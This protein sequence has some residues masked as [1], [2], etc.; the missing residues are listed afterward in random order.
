M[1]TEGGSACRIRTTN[2]AL[3]A[4]LAA[5]VV[6]GACS[7][8]APGANGASPAAAGIDPCALVTRADAERLLG[9]RVKPALRGKSRLMATG[10]TCDYVVAAPTASVGGVSGIDLTVYDDA[11]VRAPYSMF[12]S[13]A[14][15]FRY[16]MHALRVS[17]AL[18]V[19]V[20]GLGAAAYW[21]PGKD[22]LHL[23]DRG[24]YVTLDVEPAAVAP[25]SAGPS[26][27][28]HE[29]VR[30]AADIA[31]ARETVLPRLATPPSL[32]THSPHGG[33]RG[34]SS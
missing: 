9:T 24:V 20:N 17:G 29:A 26:D 11:T 13:A 2:G 7:R 31:L 19:A 32:S 3:A 6:L 5:V 8:P 23:L 28:Q 27:S 1:D 34:H 30:R 10:L 15:Y 25:G 14:E 12:K 16:G 21:Q 18:L 22:R 33:I 4:V